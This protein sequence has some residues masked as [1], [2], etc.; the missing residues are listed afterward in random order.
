MYTY[1]KL[2]TVN[3]TLSD[4]ESTMFTANNYVKAKSLEEAW[5]LNQKRRNKIVGG[6]L[7]LKLSK[8]NFNTLIDLSELGLDKIEET[9]DEFSIGAMVSLRQLELNKGLDNYSNGIVREALKAIVGVQFRNLA[10]VGGSLFL[11][12]GF[13]DVLTLFMAMDSFVELYNGGIIPLKDF[14]YMKPDNDILVRLIV[15]KTPAIYTY[16]S[17]RNASTDFPTLNCAARLSDSVIRTVFGARPSKAVIYEEKFVSAD[18]DNLD[19]LAEA[20]AG[21]AKENIHTGSNLRASAP[22][23]S[24]LVGVLAKRAYKELGGAK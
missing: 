10:T 15:K 19:S 7:W 9:D 23:R 22:Y 6:M 18:A 5:Q 12:P 8:L 20:F 14:A 13:S 1:D 3:S 17:S 16:Q 2:N 11:R 24:H 4:M 21:R